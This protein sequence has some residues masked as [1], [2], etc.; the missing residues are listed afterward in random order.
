MDGITFEDFV[1][2]ELAKVKKQE[3]TIGEDIQLLVK[4]LLLDPSVWKYSMEEWGTKP[5]ESL[6]ATRENVTVETAV[7]G[8]IILYLNKQKVIL[9]KAENRCLHRVLVAGYTRYLYS[10]GREQ[11]SATLK[12]WHEKEVKH[13]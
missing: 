3:E 7:S 12:K 10:T 1:E 4:S 13:L 6:V 5:N 9:T 8:D 11:F 2:A